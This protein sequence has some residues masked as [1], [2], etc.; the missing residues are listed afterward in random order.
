[1]IVGPLWALV[2]T[3]LE[4]AKMLPRISGLTV[5]IEPTTNAAGFWSIPFLTRGA[6]DFLF[7]F[8]ILWFFRNRGAIEAR[9][10]ID[11]SFTPEV[12]AE[13]RGLPFYQRFSFWSTILI[14]CVIALY[15]RFF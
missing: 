6:V 15:I 8:A 9:A 13:M 2:V 3:L 14:A 12:L 11:R 4:M 5:W 10:I 7:A 1:M